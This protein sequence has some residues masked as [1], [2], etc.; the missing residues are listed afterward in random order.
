MLLTA[1][2]APF[3]WLS[4]T[5]AG[6]QAAEPAAVTVDLRDHRTLVGFVDAR[7]D[8]ATLWLRLERDRIVMSTGFTWDVVASV[9][10]GDRSYT[11]AEF[12][13][14]VEQF[15]SAG[16]RRVPYR[17]PPAAPA[18][19]LPVDT[20]RVQFL[21]VEAHV[22]NWDRDADIDGIELRILPRSAD[23]IVVPVQGAIAVELHGRLLAVT[24]ATPSPPFPQLERWSQAVRPADFAGSEGA[25]YRLPF[26]SLR[27]DAT[28]D[29][30]SFGG[31]QVRM[32]AAGHGEFQADIPVRLRTFHPL[33]DHRHDYHRRHDA[34][35]RYQARHW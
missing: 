19:G 21:D 24:R 7:T 12:R 4:L 11:A 33:R 18:I 22:A 5:V 15:T 23:G 35:D 34:F 20:R 25:V 9:R 31:L 27:G 6:V 26:R 30:Q 16:A 3:V 32:H 8:D 2:Y 10:A 1:R 28:L 13:E 17:A 14:V 29:L